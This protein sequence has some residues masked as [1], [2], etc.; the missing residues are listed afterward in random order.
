MSHTHRTPWACMPS[1]IHRQSNAFDSSFRTPSPFFPFLSLT[2]AYT[3]AHSNPEFS[4][5]RQSRKS[6]KWLKL[7]TSQLYARKKWIDAR[8]LCMQLREYERVCVCMR[9]RHNLHANVRSVCHYYWLQIQLYMY[10]YVLCTETHSLSLVSMQSYWLTNVY[11]EHTLCV[12]LHY[13]YASPSLLFFCE[14]P[15]KRRESAERERTDAREFLLFLS[16]INWGT[17]CRSNE[18][19][20]GIAILRSL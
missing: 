20:N 1:I 13:M 16:S 2:F 5:K 3:W 17:H 10:M 12:W 9:Q 18:P 7:L 15:K 6:I 4:P 14:N 11:T 8:E 19:N